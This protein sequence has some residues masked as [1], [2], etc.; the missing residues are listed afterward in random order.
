MDHRTKWGAAF[1]LWWDPGVPV[2][3]RGDGSVEIDL[4]HLVWTVVGIG[5]V[6]KEAALLDDHDG[7]TMLEEMETGYACRTD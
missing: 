5:V 7:G 1:Q 4:V 2:R 6:P 3:N